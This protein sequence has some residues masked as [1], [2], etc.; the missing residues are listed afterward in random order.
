M[1]FPKDLDS[2]YKDLKNL[3]QLF[4]IFTYE[5]RLLSQAQDLLAQFMEFCVLIGSFHL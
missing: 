2:Y 5:W 1:S 4:N 3:S